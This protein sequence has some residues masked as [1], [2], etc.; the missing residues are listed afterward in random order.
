MKKIKIENNIR[1]LHFDN[2][3]IIQQESAD[4]IGVNRQAILSIE[5]GSIFLL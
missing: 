4:K 1:R 2:D 5:K 3:E